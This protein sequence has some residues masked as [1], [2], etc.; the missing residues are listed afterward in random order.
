VPFEINCFNAS[1]Y[2]VCNLF[3]KFDCLSAY[4]RQYYVSSTLERRVL[5]SADNPEVVGSVSEA[6]SHRVDLKISALALPHLAAPRSNELVGR[7][8]AASPKWSR[9]FVGSGDGLVV[10][11]TW[12]E[13][14]E[15]GWGFAAPVVVDPDGVG[16][17]I[18]G[19]LLWVK[20]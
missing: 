2:S 20:A 19:E 11:L 9:G 4:F 10:F 7:V 5:A 8:G 3:C 14:L 13:F 16:F 6:K 15:D 18:I 17:A 12:A 1:G